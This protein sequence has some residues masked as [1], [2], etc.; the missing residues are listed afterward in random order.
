MAQKRKYKRR[1]KVDNEINL[2]IIGTIVF[3]ILL[4]VLLFTNSGAVGQKLNE[5]LG[6]MMG[7][8]RYILPIG[9]FAI[10]IIMACNE[11]KKEYITNL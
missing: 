10:A 1:K 8:L 3:S 4:A 2:K 11:E 5:I 6:G 9:T 7:I